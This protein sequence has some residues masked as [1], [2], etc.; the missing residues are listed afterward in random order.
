MARFYFAIFG[1][2][3]SP[4]SC[5]NAYTNDLLDFMD[6]MRMR[7]KSL[8]YALDP[9]AICNGI[10]CTNTN[11]EIRGCS[12]VDA[13]DDNEFFEIM[14]AATGMRFGSENYIQRAC[15]TPV[16]CYTDEELADQC[17]SGSERESAYRDSIWTQVIVLTEVFLSLKILLEIGFYEMIPEDV[18]KQMKTFTRRIA[19]YLIIAHEWTD[20]GSEIEWFVDEWDDINIEDM[21]NLYD[22]YPD[23]ILND[24]AL[25]VDFLTNGILEPLPFEERDIIDDRQYEQCLIDW[26]QRG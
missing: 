13:Y 25:I 26:F 6:F 9:D 20:T 5:S 17:F 1:G 19:Q 8:L 3:N 21:M 16:C 14:E 10:M 24:A 12:W 18:V 4:I 23:G 2:W 15:G 22:N 7:K 11:G